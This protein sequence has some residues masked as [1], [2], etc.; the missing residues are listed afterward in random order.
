MKLRIGFTGITGMLG[1]NFLD[2]Y[3]NKKELQKTF[4]IVGFTRN[5]NLDFK[6][7]YEKEDGSIQ[8]KKIDYYNQDNL[9]QSLQSI[10]ILI[11]AAAI[12]K[13]FFYNEFLQ[14]NLN[15]T[16]NIIKVIEDNNLPIKKFIFISSQSVLGPSYD[17]YLNEESNYNPLTYYGKSKVEAEKQIKNSKIDWLIVRFPAIFGKY[18]YDGLILFKIASRGFIIDTTW[19]EYTLS[20]IFAEDACRLLFYIL[21][22]NNI[23]RKI[24]HLCYDQPIKIKNLMKSIIDIIYGINKKRIIKIPITKFIIYFVSFILTIISIFNKK[25]K[26]IGLSKINE[27]LNPSWLLSNDL[28]KKLLNIES[29]EKISELKNIIEWYKDRRLI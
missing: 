16:V 23:N 24:L 11:H 4:D 7:K 10:D 3:L 6:K 5:E 9:K 18:D 26:I 2:F 12:T 28:T 25:A 13:G 17:K 8:I 22:K 14:G 21:N 27:F 19:K 15:S 29:I 1:K 20:Y